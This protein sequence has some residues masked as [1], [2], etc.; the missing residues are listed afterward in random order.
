[1][2]TLQWASVMDRTAILPRGRAQARQPR[3]T[4]F[5][6]LSTPYFPHMIEGAVSVSDM[7]VVP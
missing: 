6:L 2:A 4:L 3:T 1:M 7:R 5:S